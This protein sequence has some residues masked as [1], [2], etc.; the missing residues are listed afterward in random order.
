MRFCALYQRGSAM[1]SCFQTVR[2]LWLRPLSWGNTH[3]SQH[4]EDVCTCGRQLV[5]CVCVCVRFEIFHL[6]TQH[7]TSLEIAFPT[8][9]ISPSRLVSV[10]D[11][12]EDSP[13]CSNAV[14]GSSFS[15][16][17]GLIDWSLLQW[18]QH[19]SARPPLSSGK[20]SALNR[21]IAAILSSFHSLLIILLARPIQE[22]P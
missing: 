19:M 8:L 21:N 3:T 14:P 4:P 10:T 1:S 20:E 13:G 9:H 22:R 15:V 5:A 2:L 7:Q 11:V 12:D 17:Y 18:L 6:L 16:I